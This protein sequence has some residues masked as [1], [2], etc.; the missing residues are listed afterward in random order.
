MLR[1]GICFLCFFLFAINE[2]LSQIISN[3]SL[4]ITGSI[5]A[6]ISKP[7]DFILKIEFWNKTNRTIKVYDTL[8]PGHEIDMSRNFNL[9][10]EENISGKFK[11]RGTR[12]Y[13]VSLFDSG[14]DIVDF[15]KTDLGPGKKRVLTYNINFVTSFPV[16]S[17]RLQF[18]IR[19]KT[20]VKVLSN[21]E[22]YFRPIYMHSA[23]WIYFKV[24]KP[25]NMQWQD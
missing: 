20:D 4:T 7:E 19:D 11:E 3:D 2:S 13:H 23:G 16:N 24:I 14:R 25:Y 10:I 1:I 15:I 5:S 22:K 18:R 21:G 12:T 8:V 9:L 6:V 17:Y